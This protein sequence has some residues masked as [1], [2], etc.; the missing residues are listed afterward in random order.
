LEKLPRTLVCT[1]VLIAGSVAPAF[2]T[3]SLLAFRDSNPLNT[4]SVFQQGLAITQI[5]CQGISLPGTRAALPPGI[6]LPP[7][8]TLPGSKP[9]KKKI[10]SFR[11]ALAR[12]NKTARKGAVGKVVKQ[13]TKGPALRTEGNAHGVAVAAMTAGAPRLALAAMLAAEKKDPRD[14]MNLVNAAAPLT[15]LGMEE[16]AI[17]LLEHA[18]KMKGPLPAVMG[19]AGRAV[20]DNNL[21]YANARLQRHGKAVAAL[22]R[23][24]ASAPAL[25]EAN[26]NIGKELV[27]AGRGAEALR[28]MKNAQ[29]RNKLDRVIPGGVANDLIP[30][31]PIASQV[32]D[33]SAGTDGT[34]PAFSAPTTPGQSAAFH[35]S[36]AA[37]EQAAGADASAV[38]AARAAAGTR[39]AAQPGNNLATKLR[40]SSIAN[41]VNTSLAEPDIKAAYETAIADLAEADKVTKDFWVGDVTSKHMQCL[42]GGDYEACFKPWCQDHTASA[43]GRFNSAY[44]AADT[45]MRNYWKLAG[46]RE[47]GVAANLD[48]Q[49]WH[50]RAMGETREHAGSAYRLLLGTL[51]GWVGPVKFWE[52]LCVAGNEPPPAAADAPPTVESP[53]A[54]PQALSPFSGTFKNSVEIP[55]AKGGGE[56]ATKVDVSVKVSCSKLEVEISKKVPGT[57]EIIS[58]FGKGEQDFK[59]DTTTVVVGAKGSILGLATGQSGF[60]ITNGKNGIEDFGWRVGAGGSADPFGGLTNAS[61]SAKVWG[62]SEN[63]SFVGSIDYIPTAFGFGGP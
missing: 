44:S 15:T 36:L 53:G 51:R 21:G 24:L 49:D 31:V 11:V 9:K 32:V 18:A 10:P 42:A 43:Q 39:A 41:L 19:I 7:G 46:K 12:A 16:E 13:L 20:L 27:C 40:R 58:V 8:F 61:V 4:D 25:A 59:K 52:Q 29:A 2:A 26:S 35:P 63:I 22:R 30:S 5:S 47:T 45:A 33:L 3:S 37:M 50:D 17:A 60:Y 34:L 28:Y 14:R 48:Q 55:P 38:T 6:T 1:V 57:G 54:C 62:G 23:A 56:K